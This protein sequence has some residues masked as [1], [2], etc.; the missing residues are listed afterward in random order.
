M[1]KALIPAVF[2]LGSLLFGVSVMV[3][4]FANAQGEQKVTQQ[5]IQALK[6]F[7]NEQNSDNPKDNQQTETLDS[8]S[9]DEE[10][11]PQEVQVQTNNDNQQEIITFSNVPDVQ[12]TNDNLKKV[13]NSQVQT[14]NIQKVQNKIE[15]AK[16]QQLAQAQQQAQ[17]Q[18][19]IDADNKQKKA[20][21]QS[22]QDN[23]EIRSANVLSQAA[24]ETL[25]QQQLQAQQEILQQQIAEAQKEK[26][27]QMQEQAKQE[28]KA[29]Q[30]AKTQARQQALAQQQDQQVND[31]F[32]PNKVISQAQVQAQLQ[33]QQQALA[34]AQQQDQ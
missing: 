1:N 27:A 2:L 12:S 3:P 15:V 24:K 8:Q 14:P 7:F 10:A 31:D 19:Q 6:L 9:V 16:S 18:A 20:A 17:M 21:L 11:S 32:H 5:Q 25:A 34:Q 23:S 13:D 4:Q 28:S 22:V 33:A 26:L 30:E 29:L